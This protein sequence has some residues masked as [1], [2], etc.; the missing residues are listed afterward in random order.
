ML[1][2]GWAVA[3]SGDRCRV[4]R[5]KQPIRSVFINGISHVVAVTPASALSVTQT[6]KV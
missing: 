2:G 5:S 4:K 3:V 6:I 1:A